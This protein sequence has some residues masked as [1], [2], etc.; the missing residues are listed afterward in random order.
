MRRLPVPNIYG[1]LFS[2]AQKVVA[3][4]GAGQGIGLAL[5]EGFAAAG[6]AAS[7]RAP[8]PMTRCRKPASR[9]SPHPTR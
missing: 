8:W 6:A 9:P 7:T 2:V 1:N 3:I 4:T 5:A